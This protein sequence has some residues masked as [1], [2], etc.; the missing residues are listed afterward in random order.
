MKRERWRGEEIR[1]GE[2]RDGQPAHRHLSVVSVKQT[3]LEKSQVMWIDDCQR[4]TL[5]SG[6]DFF[7]SSLSCGG[8]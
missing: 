7:S 3:L 5:I 6:L 2:T 8:T 1:A 4:P